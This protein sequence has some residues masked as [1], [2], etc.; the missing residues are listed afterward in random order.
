MSPNNSYQTIAQDY[1]DG[2]TVLFA[3]SGEPTGE[4]GGRGPASPEE[5]VAQA[6]E[7]SPVSAQL[8][9]ELAAQLRETDDLAV[10][11]QASVRLLALALTDLE[12]SASLL[13][14][15][16]DE[17]QGIPWEKSEGRERSI[18]I[19]GQIENNLQILLGHEEVDLD[20][21]ERGETE[22]KD[23]DTARIKLSN[24]IEDTLYLILKRA[25]NTGELALKGLTNL[26]LSELTEAVG[27]ID[28][29]IAEILGQGEVSRI[30]NTFREFLQRAW[31]SVV[32]LLGQQLAE[33]AGERMI[34]WVQELNEGQSLIAILEKLYQTEKTGA[35]LKQLVMDSQGELG[36]FTDGIKGVNALNSAYSK[37]IDWAEKML[38]WMEKRRFIFNASAAVLPQGE[39]ILASL[40]ILLGTYVIM[41]GADYV[42]AP[43]PNRLDRVPGVRRIV[44]AQLASE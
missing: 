25:S 20:E 38:Q 10:R 2:V 13:E 23:I 35:V 1:A 12:I 14:A 44:E 29:G 8:T 26:A 4:R 22:I 19:L 16:T 39:L 37:K 15:A 31:E 7:L 24:T 11:T 36:K 33:V 17:E 43:P 28:K 3:R 30:Y 21:A 34:E 32:E 40:Y 9:Q 18:D 42:D 27:L 41:V 5:M 6:E